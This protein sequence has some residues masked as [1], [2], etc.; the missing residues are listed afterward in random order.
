MDRE[1]SIGRIRRFGDFEIEKKTRHIKSNELDGTDLINQVLL[2]HRSKHRKDHGQL[3]L[4]NVSL[5]S[6]LIQLL[7]QLLYI[8]AICV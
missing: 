5:T 4:L 8:E 2:T 6:N 3:R 1:Q 7:K